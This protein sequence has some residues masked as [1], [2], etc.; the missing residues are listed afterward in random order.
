[1][2]RIEPV[3][4]RFF[5]VFFAGLDFPQSLFLDCFCPFHPIAKKNAFLKS[6]RIGDSQVLFVSGGKKPVQRKNSP[7][8]QQHCQA[9]IGYV[10]LGMFL[11]ADT[12]LDKIDPINRATPDVLAV[13]L[14]I[15]RGLK[16]WELMQ[17]VAQRLAEFDPNNIQWIISYAYATRRADSVEAAKKILLA[18]ETRFPN[19]PV[20]Q[21]NLVCYECE[22][23]NLESAKPYLNRAFKIDPNWRLQALDDPDLE[24][25]WASLAEGK[26]D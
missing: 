3:P 8:D 10:E 13:R 12:E 4:V 19:E 17:V 5:P 25:L 1:L 22:L 2:W 14:E 15:Y 23:G 21:F 6:R 9:A 7:P 16:K 20:I 26:E 24:P 11:D 18:A